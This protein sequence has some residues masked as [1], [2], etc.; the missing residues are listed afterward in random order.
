MDIPSYNIDSSR[1]LHFVMKT[2]YVFSEN[3]YLAAG[4]KNKKLKSKNSII[5]KVVK[6][7]YLY[8]RSDVRNYQAK[9]E[10]ALYNEYAKYI[11]DNHDFF[12]AGKFHTA[13]VYNLIHEINRRDLSNMKKLLEDSLTNVIKKVLK[14]IKSPYKFD[15]SM[16]FQTQ[17]IKLP[18]SDEKM[19]SINIK[20][21]IIID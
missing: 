12:I 16:I 8:K 21:S 10:K 5:A 14:K 9:L 4:I 18:S 19:E 13:F 6:T 15:D 2:N 17:E 20:M 3:T 1:Y 11:A 7:P